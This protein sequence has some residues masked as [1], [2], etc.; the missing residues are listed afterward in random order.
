MKRKQPPWENESGVQVL[1]L[2]KTGEHP[3]W[4]RDVN[5]PHLHPDWPRVVL[6]DLTAKQFKEFDQDPLTFAKK[7][8]LYPEQEML[9]ISQCAKP[10]TGKGIPR[11]AESS[12]WTVAYL[13]VARSQGCC[14][15]CPQ[16]TTG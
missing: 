8:N 3:D 11:V 16:S 15:A 9:W 7:Y 4:P 5:K 1:R 6:L 12:R 14:A 13:H 2:Y 10:P